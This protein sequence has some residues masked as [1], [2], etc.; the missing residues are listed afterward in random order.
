VSWT[1][2]AYGHPREAIVN[3]LASHVSEKRP[4]ATVR[5]AT[6][7]RSFKAVPMEKAVYGTG[8]DGTVV[9]EATTAGT[10]NVVKLADT[11]ESSITST[12]PLINLNTAT[13]DEL[14]GLPMIGPTRARAI[15]AER[16][17]GGP[18]AGVDELAARVSGIGSSTLNAIR[19]LVTT[20][21]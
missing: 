18:F 15:V 3:M 19:E 9:L 10:W 11:R 21:N 1:A 20:G 8:W 6:K 13:V 2:F 12:A 5:V 17:R 16:R 4:R 7:V 14:V